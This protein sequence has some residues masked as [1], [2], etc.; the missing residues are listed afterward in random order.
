MFCFKKVGE[1]TREFANRI[2][3][4]HGVPDRQ[5]VAICGKLDPQA[6]GV[7]RVLIGDQT[8]QFSHYLQSNKTYEFSIVMGISTT[9]DDIMGEI[10]DINSTPQD[11]KLVK[12]FMRNGV[13]TQTIQKYHPI[14][15]KKI[16]KDSGKKRP[17]WYWNKRNMLEEGDLPSKPVQVFSLVEMNTPIEMS[18]Q[19]YRDI[20]LGRLNTITDRKCFNIDSI[21]ADWEF[22]RL[23]KIRLLSYKIKVSSGFFVRM[24]AKEIKDQLHIP[25]HI[26]GINRV[27]VEDI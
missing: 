15:G 2:R 6:E 5:K 7:T 16:R 25:V 9:S 20:V 27:E 14:S 10:E 11:I 17:L 8:S 23:E 26:F 13:A 19:K 21:V 3:A 12:S 22:V 1:T 24:I 4:E 18:F